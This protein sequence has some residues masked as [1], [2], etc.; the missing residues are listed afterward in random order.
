MHNT[1][2]IVPGRAQYITFQLAPT[3]TLGVL[4]IYAYNLTTSRTKLWRQI[5][6]YPLPEAH[7][8]CGGDFNMIES[9]QDKKGGLPTTNVSRNELAA[10]TRLL[11]HLGFADVHRLDD[12]TRLSPKNFTWDNREAGANAIMTRIDRFYVSGQALDNGGSYGIL[13]TI[14]HLSDHSPILLCL[15]QRGTSRPQPPVFASALLLDKEQVA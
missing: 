13:P 1:G 4:N 7:W 15:R 6:E 2:I 10:W 3:Y 12:F 5:R 9:I 8:V 14:R 11:T